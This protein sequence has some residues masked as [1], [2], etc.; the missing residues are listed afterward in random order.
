[1]TIKNP[2]S[3]PVS[4]S[5][6]ATAAVL[7]VTPSSG[8]VPAQSEIQL[9][10]RASGLPPAS[11]PGENLFVD[12]GPGQFDV[13]KIRVSGQAAPRAGSVRAVSPGQAC[14]PRE[15][16]PVL[17]LPVNLEAPA[18]VPV[19]LAVQVLDDC[20]QPLRTG[21]VSVEMDN[22]DASVEL[23]P[24]GDGW[25]FGSWT[26]LRET[27][28]FSGLVALAFSTDGALFGEFR[29][30]ARVTRNPDP[31]PAVEVGSIVNAATLA[32]NQPHAPGEFVSFFGIG[33]ADRQE[34]ATTLPLPTLLGGTSIQ[35]GGVDVPILFASP[36]QVNAIVP[37]GLAARSL[38]P[39]VVRRGNR[40]N[41]PGSIQILDAHPGVFTVNQSGQGRGVIVDA[42]FR[43][44]DA[45]NPARPGD[46]VILFLTGLGETS[47]A[48]RTGAPGPS[49]PLSRTR[50]GVTAT[51]GGGSAEV[52]FAGLA[53]GFA[54]LYQINVQVPAGAPL[55][56][57]VP[58]VVTAGGLS[59]PPVTMAVR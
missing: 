44:I 4:F 5:A 43:L 47:P 6:F 13:V 8:T 30:S 33:L 12:L 2:T 41:A 9:T 3:S 10:V 50:L 21:Q 32:A 18:G 37:F 27:A 23:L 28:G 39:V 34:T 51:I 38:H 31:P 17:S 7:T 19:P 42:N 25:W 36:G 46:V 26:P 45:A 20:G 58:V 1:V 49:S 48:V 54:G 35:I 55:G 57:D 53:P 16:A 52:L 29:D 14:Q 22:G 24:R 11:S 56:A 15:L 40:V 59:S